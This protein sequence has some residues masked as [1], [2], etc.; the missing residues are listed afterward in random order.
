VRIARYAGDTPRQDQAP[1]AGGGITAFAGVPAVSQ[2]GGVVEGVMEETLVGFEP[3]RVRLHSEFVR[4]HAV[5]RHD[6]E[7]FDAVGTGHGRSS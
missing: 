1:P 7:A 2:R 4:D 3:E 5:G 6:G